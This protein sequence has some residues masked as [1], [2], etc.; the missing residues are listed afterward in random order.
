MYILHTHPKTRIN[1]RFI[2][3]T[4]INASPVTNDIKNPLVTGYPNDSSTRYQA[5]FYKYIAV[6][7]VTET[8]VNYPYPYVSEKTLRPIAC[9]RMFIILGAQNTLALLRSK[10]FATF[11]DFINEDYDSIQDPIIRFKAVEKEVKKICNTPLYE[12]KEYMTKNTEKFEHNFSVLVS[13]Q[14]NELKQI[15]EEYDIK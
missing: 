11:D 4:S 2:T 5:D 15:A 13:L 14:E 3:D 10:G 9:K 6:D 8:V 12:I 7:I 1:D